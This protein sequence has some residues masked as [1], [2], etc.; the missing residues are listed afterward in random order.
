MRKRDCA[1]PQSRL[2]ALSPKRAKSPATCENA[3]IL[4]RARA[5]KGEAQGILHDIKV[6]GIFADPHLSFSR[7]VGSF[8]ARTHTFTR[9]LR[10]VCKLDNS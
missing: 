1:G 3:K 6:K 10:V 8:R 7:C 2:V 5:H 9:C 4:R